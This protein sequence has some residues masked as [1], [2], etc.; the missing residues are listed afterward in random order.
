MILLIDL[1][2]FTDFSNNGKFI[3]SLFKKINQLQLRFT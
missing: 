1:D 2:V 3:T